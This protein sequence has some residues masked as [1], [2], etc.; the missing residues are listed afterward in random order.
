MACPARLGSPQM[1]AHASAASGARSTDIRICGIPSCHPP[2]VIL[3]QYLQV[4]LLVEAGLADL[5][6]RLPVTAAIPTLM[7]K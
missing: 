7:W 5:Q 6:S 2:P 3:L 4:L 1:A